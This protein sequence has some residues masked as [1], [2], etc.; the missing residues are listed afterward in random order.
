M[1][2]LDKGKQYKKILEIFYFDISI[3]LVITRSPSVN[4][5]IWKTH[6]KMKAVKVIKPKS[7]QLQFIVHLLMPSSI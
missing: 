5:R 3:L 2:Y 1:I 7:L 4:K 6:L